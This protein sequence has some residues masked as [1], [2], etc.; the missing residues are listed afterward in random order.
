MAFCTHILYC[1]ASAITGKQFGVKD[2]PL[3]PDLS[4]YLLRTNRNDVI[5]SDML[6]KLRT[7]ILFCLFIFPSFEKVWGNM[8]F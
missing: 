2:Y 7:C 1:V 5:P 8:D 6:G 3:A 4:L